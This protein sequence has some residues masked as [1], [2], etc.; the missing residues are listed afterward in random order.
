MAIY[1]KDKCI[2][3]PRIKGDFI[4]MPLGRGISWK[5]LGLVKC[6][7]CNLCLKKPYVYCPCCNMRVSHNLRRK[8]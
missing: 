3:D 6:S 8:L 2:S 5:R 1:C 7:V 4:K